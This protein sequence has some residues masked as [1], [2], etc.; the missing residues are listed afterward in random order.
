HRARH[1]QTENDIDNGSG[2]VLGAN[3]TSHEDSGQDSED[4]RETQHEVLLTGEWSRQRRGPFS[5]PVILSIPKE[6][7]CNKLVTGA[8]LDY[9]SYSSAK[10]RFSSSTTAGLRFP[11]EKFRD[12]RPVK[13]GES[14]KAQAARLPSRLSRRSSRRFLRSGEPDRGGAK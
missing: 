13:C 1:V 6:R 10:R 2:F 8:S 9:S 14:S 7:L 12:V 4:R 3:R 11:E 5:F